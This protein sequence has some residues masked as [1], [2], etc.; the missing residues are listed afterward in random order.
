M[1]Y[2]ARR[3][4]LPKWSSLGLCTLMLAAL[5]AACGSDSPTTAPANPAGATAAT[6]NAAVIVATTTGPVAQTTIATT[7]AATT[8]AAVTAATTSAAATTSIAATSAAATTVARSTAA[9][10]TAAATT[11]PAPQAATPANPRPAVGNSYPAGPAPTAAA[12]A[13]GLVEVTLQVPDQF[14][15]GNFTTPRKLKLPQGFSISL[16]SQLGS[17][18]RFGTISPDGRLFV[19]ERGTNRVMWLKD[20]GTTGDPQV[21]A[22]GLNGPH[23]LAFQT[24]GGQMYLYVADNNSVKRFAYENGMTKANKGEVIVSGL[25]TGGNHTTRSIAFGPDGKMY[26]SVGSSCNVCEEADER[27][28]AVLQYNADG[29]GGRIY[30]RGLRN[31]VGIMFHPET[32]ELWG[33][34]N[35]RDNLGDGVD[36]NNNIPPEEI[37]I[38]Q[39]NANYGWPYCFSNQVYDNR[40]GRKNADFCKQTIPPALPMQAHSAPLGL[41]FYFP[42]NQ[43]F[44][45]DFRGD[46]FVGFHGS[47]NRSPATGYKVVRVRVKDGR[48]VSYEDFATGWLTGSTANW[49]R[50]VAP[51]V[52]PDGSLFVTDD[53]NNVIYKITYGK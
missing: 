33:V 20:N 21:F 24:V 23:G 30:A 51:I 28:A 16:Y 3:Y 49:G 10:T 11:A 40:Y 1:N 27:R 22:E 19:S 42:K 32:G 9:P 6:T 36:Q 12:P 52:G 35:S 25:P 31:E 45:A 29:T 48:P 18:L 5:L 17:N 34:E 44:P 46:V 14:K 43:Q 38:I 4:R 2:Q 8:N 7:S 15:K 37:N 53:D 47:W 41:D 26:V 13:G 39:D 50:P